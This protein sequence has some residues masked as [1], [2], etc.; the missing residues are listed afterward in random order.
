LAQAHYNY[1]KQIP[2]TIKRFIPNKIRDNLN[3]K[4]LDNPIGLTA[5]I[6]SHNTLPSMAQK[7]RKPMWE[8]PGLA[9]ES[10]DRAAVMGYNKQAYIDTQKQYKDFVTDLLERLGTI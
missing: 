2:D 8:I 4:M 1:A 7:Y 5:V 10:E 6:H 3:P 9:L